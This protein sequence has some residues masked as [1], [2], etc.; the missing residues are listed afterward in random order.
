MTRQTPQHLI[1]RDVPT[2][3]SAVVPGTD[4]AHAAN[5]FYTV[6]RHCAIEL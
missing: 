6:R 1:P 3:P 5:C 4:E 2:L